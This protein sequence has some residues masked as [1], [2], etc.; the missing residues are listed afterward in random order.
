MQNFMKNR[1]KV[2][3][4]GMTRPHDVRAAVELGVDAIGVIFYPPS[5]RCIDLSSARKLRDQIPAFISM[6][7]VFVDAE[8]ETINYTASAC[9][10][11]LVQLHGNE[12]DAF[13]CS[14]NR[15]FIKAIRARNREQVEHD[16]DSYPNARALLLDP[17]VSGLPGGTGTVLGEDLW[18][19]PASQKLILAG[20]LSAQ[21][22]SQAV[23]TK[24]PFAVD[25]NSGLESA[26]GIKD[27]ALM[28]A[29]FAALS[30]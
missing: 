15:P 23:S 11:D 19:Q 18:P 14:L 12:S 2:K 22:I 25:L 17:Y 10:L 26:P 20:G 29:A 21:N 28:A 27:H 7:G 3:I 4:C 16:I 30:R 9:G 24:Q 8:A 13:A 6:V 1:I 5:A